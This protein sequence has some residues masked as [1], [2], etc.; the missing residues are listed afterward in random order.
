M[1]CELRVHVPKGYKVP[2]GFQLVPATDDFP[3]REYRA[4]VQ[5]GYRSVSAVAAKLNVTERA[6][7]EASDMNTQDVGRVFYVHPLQLIDN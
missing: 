6:A 2:V 3:V 7:Y 5:G 1:K 4:S